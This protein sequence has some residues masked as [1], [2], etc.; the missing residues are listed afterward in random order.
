M[1]PMASGCDYGKNTRWYMVAVF[2]ILGTLAFT[3]IGIAWAGRSDLTQHAEKTQA[4]AIAVARMDE[5]L[6]NIEAQ[7]VLINGKL[8]RPERSASAERGGAGG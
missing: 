7:L 1:T 2:A 5:R 6:K 4:D 8:D 3:S